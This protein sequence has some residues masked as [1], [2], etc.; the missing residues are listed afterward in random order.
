MVRLPW[1]GVIYAGKDTYRV[2]Q[3]ERS[4]FWEVIVW[5]ILSK[6]FICTC[7]LFRTVS[8]IELFHC[9]VPKLLIRKR[10][11]VLYCFWYRYLLFKWQSWYS[12]PSIIHFRKFHRQHQCTLQLVWGHG[13][14]L[15][16][17]VY[18]DIELI[19]IFRMP[20]CLWNLLDKH[21]MINTSNLLISTMKETGS[22]YAHKSDKFRKGWRHNTK[23]GNHWRKLTL[24]NMKSTE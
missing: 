18:S 2:S 15:V 11:Y 1:G 24:L 16:C 22:F 9:T 12:L 7:V 4:I 20:Y 3:E 13:L 10:Y 17:T 21:W 14:L 8:D 19:I 6:K 23:S 5:L